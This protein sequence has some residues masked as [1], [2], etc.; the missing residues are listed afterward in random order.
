MDRAAFHSREFKNGF[1]R[2]C[3]W[4]LPPFFGIVFS[5][6]AEGQNGPHQA[7]NFA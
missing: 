1:E 7:V 5:Q 2:A 4:R 3:V 6:P